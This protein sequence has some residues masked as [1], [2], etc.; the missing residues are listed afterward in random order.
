[1]E[2]QSIWGGHGAKERGNFLHPLPVVQNNPWPNPHMHIYF[3]NYGH[4]QKIYV[5]AKQTTTAVLSGA[6]VGAASSQ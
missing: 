4:N 3:T 5:F 1:M 2:T 6:E